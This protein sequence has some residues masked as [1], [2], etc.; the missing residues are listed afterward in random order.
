MKL[1]IDPDI[2]TATTIDSSFYNDEA[3][4]A[5]ARE[6]IFARSWQWI[7]ALDD[8]KQPGTLA[9]REMLPGLLSEPL[10]L[11]RDED[12]GLRCLSNVCTHRGNILVHAACKSKHIRC[13]YHGRRFDLTGKMLSMPEFDQAKNFPAPMD[14]LPGVPFAAWQN[15]GFAGVAPVA[16]LG[17]FLAEVNARLD[18]MPIDLFV[19]D[20]TRD[21]D[22]LLNAHWAL[23]V[24][25][26]LEGFHIPFVHPGLNAVLDYKTYASEIGRYANLQLALAKEGEAAFEIPPGSPDHGKRV[27]AYYYWVFP[28]LMLNFYPW[29]LSLN[30]IEPQGVAKTR[31]RFRSF[32]WDASKLDSGAG[33]GLDQVE[34]EDEAVVLMVQRG[35]R[36]RF[37]QHGRYSPTREMGTHHFHRLIC[38]FMNREG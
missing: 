14:N 27:A 8:V 3:N 37:Y 35:V 21:H 2:T 10:V 1:T 38:E 31:I 5:L 23:Y 34:M 7:G 30:I 33:S 13:Q 32:V 12:N 29:G 25:N 26:Y 16:P 17:E 24:E 22:F 6:K 4:Y 9:P 19:H 28:N 20:P 11:S 36:S 18:W 15:H